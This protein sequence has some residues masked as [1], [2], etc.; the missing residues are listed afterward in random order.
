MERCWLGRWQS[1]KV[2]H[3]WWAMTIVVT[4]GAAVERVIA[5]AVV[6]EARLRIL[7]I[8]LAI[9]GALTLWLPSF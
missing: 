3:G 4:V 2:D 9:V 8:V 7:L 1:T 5:N 6:P